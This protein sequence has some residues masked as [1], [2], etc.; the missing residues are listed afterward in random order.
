VTPKVYLVDTGLL[1]DLL[2]TSGVTAFALAWFSA[3]AP[4]PCRSAIGFGPF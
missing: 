4:K 2:G 1:A 3:V